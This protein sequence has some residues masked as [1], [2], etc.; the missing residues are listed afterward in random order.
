M[1]ADQIEA[2]KRIQQQIEFDQE[3]I[4][5]RESN[6][7]R[8]YR[9]CCAFIL[10]IAIAFM[11][12]PSFKNILFGF[13][14]NED[15]QKLSTWTL[16]GT[17]C[18]EPNSTSESLKDSSQQQVQHSCKIEKKIEL[19]DSASPRVWAYGLQLTAWTGALGLL[20]WAIVALCREE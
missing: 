9:H 13:N 19:I 11:V 7:F 4:K 16:T 3:R 8:I 14:I 17:S 2:E 10:S 20:L 1:S 18:H 6:Y 12:I 15:S 5:W